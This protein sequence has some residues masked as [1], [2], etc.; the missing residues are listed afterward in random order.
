MKIKYLLAVILKF[1]KVY[2]MGK[3]VFKYMESH[4]KVSG[5]AGIR[6]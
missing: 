1:S 3:K 4:K 5:A 2:V 6:L